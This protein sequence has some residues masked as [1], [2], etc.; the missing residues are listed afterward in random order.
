MKQADIS[1]VPKDAIEQNPMV[2]SP[3]SK[4]ESDPLR[5]ERDIPVYQDTEGW[6]ALNTKKKTVAD[7]ALTISGPDRLPA[8]IAYLK[9]GSDLQPELRPL[10]QTVS[11]AVNNPLECLDYS[12]VSLTSF[13][14]EMDQDY[15]TINNWAMTA[16]TMQS[17]FR[18]HSSFRYLIDDLYKT[19]SSVFRDIPSLD[20]AYRGMYAFIE[21]HHSSLLEAISDPSDNVALEK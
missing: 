4:E 17:L 10:Y 16:I 3:P 15:A 20:A 19:N 13:L 14:A 7:Y 8:M 12:A 21:G 9:V 6:S 2:P 5:A 1:G 18:E 11:L